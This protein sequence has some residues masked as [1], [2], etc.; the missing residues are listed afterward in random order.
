MEFGNR[1]ILIII[2][3]LCTHS[4]KYR[5]QYHF[6]HCRSSEHPTWNPCL[7]ESKGVRPG[8]TNCEVPRERLLVRASPVV[9]Y[10]KP[11]SG[12][13][14]K[15]VNCGLGQW[16]RSLYSSFIY[17]LKL[18]FGR[19]FLFWGGGGVTSF[20]MFCFG[21]TLRFGQLRVFFIKTQPLFKAR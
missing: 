19:L 8:P 20:R 15:D 14:W 21:K 4:T 12:K 5:I 6:Q 2:C 16:G 18:G 9:L 7:I 11:E 1:R 13:R 17:R 3:T 10:P